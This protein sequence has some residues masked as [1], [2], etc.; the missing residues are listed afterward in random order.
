MLL[1]PVF[2]YLLYNSDGSFVNLWLTIHTL[3]ATK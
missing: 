3:L 2:K 1:L